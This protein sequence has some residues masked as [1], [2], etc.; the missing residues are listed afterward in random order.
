MAEIDAFEPA[1]LLSKVHVAFVIE[2]VP[3]MFNTLK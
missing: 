2:A 3:L 1:G